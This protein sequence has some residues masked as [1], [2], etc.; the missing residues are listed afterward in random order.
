[1]PGLDGIEACQEIRKITNAPIIFVSCHNDDMDKILGLRVGGDDYLAKPFHPGELV[2]R[3]KAQLRRN[4]ITQ[5]PVA[6]PKVI[7]C[8]TLQINLES[9][10]VFLEGQ[11]IL[12][13]AKEFEIL[14]ILAQSPHRVFTHDQ[15]M[16]LAWKEDPLE[17]DNRTVMVHISNL[18]KKIEANP[19]CPRY[20]MTVR[21]VGYRFGKGEGG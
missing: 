9:H 17:Y 14:T 1:M 6:A 16:R 5:Q 3:V 10:E 15:I 11:E 4:R 19:Q 8:G 18:R 2:A 7:D 12:L 21:G 20:V 13:S